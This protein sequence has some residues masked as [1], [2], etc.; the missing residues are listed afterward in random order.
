M[1]KEFSIYG[2][3]DPRTMQ[4]RYVG[5]T[6]RPVFFRAKDHEMHALTGQTSCSSLEWISELLSLNLRP[7]FLVQESFTTREEGF[8][9]EIAAIAYYRSIGCPLLNKSSGGSGP[10]GCSRSTKTRAL[11]GAAKAGVPKSPTHRKNLAESGGGKPFKDDLGNTYENIHDAGT[12]LGLQYQNI[13]KV[14][15]GRRKHVGGRSFVYL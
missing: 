3:F 14:L 6:S 9:A 2:L 15:K 1:R 11:M 8:A 12:K 4:L 7:L 10:I 5:V 13:W